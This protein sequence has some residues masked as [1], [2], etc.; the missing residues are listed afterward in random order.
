MH[1]WATSG[2]HNISVLRA[3]LV[4]LVVWNILMSVSPHSAPAAQELRRTP[5]LSPYILD[6]F[7]LGARISINNAAYSEYQCTPSEQYAEFTWCTK[8]RRSRG[9]SGSSE[10][11]D[12]VLRAQDGTIVYV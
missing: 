4:P 12:S 9:S 10:V 6:G 3:R 5:P 1:L 8:K 2:R 11:M 7:T